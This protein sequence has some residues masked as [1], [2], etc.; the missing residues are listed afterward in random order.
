[1]EKVLPDVNHHEYTI[2]LQK[3]HGGI[4]IMTD[5]GS[6]VFAVDQAGKTYHVDVPAV[7]VRDTTGAGDAFRAGIVYGCLHKWTLAESL[8]LAVAAG[9][10]QVARDASREAPAT[11]GETQALVRQTMRQ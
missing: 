6:P 1:M 7:T 10:L 4:V 11:L 9:S 8:K 5:G 2:N 3:K